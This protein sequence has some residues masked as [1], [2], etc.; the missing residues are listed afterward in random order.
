M[1]R[2][3]LNKE[4]DFQKKQVKSERYSQSKFHP[5][6]Y[7]RLYWLKNDYKIIK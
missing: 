4:Y 2:F 5:Q 6:R 3:L 7:Y 1:Q